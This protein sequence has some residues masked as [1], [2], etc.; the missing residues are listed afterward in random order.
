MSDQGEHLLKTTIQVLTQ[1]F[2]IH[3]QKNT[4][5]HPQANGAIESFNNILEHD[6]T[7][8]YNGQ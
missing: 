1:E 4:L 6:L 7:K 3:H 8:D 5:Y 2:M